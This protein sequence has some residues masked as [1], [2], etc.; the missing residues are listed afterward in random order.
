MYDS[1][2]VQIYVAN[3]YAFSN[4]YELVLWI[5][6][7]IRI[8]LPTNLHISLVHRLYVLQIHIDFVWYRF[9]TDSYNVFIVQLTVL[10]LTYVF[11]DTDVY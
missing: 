9:C 1:A 5:H 10:V 8:W 11:D 7:F 4:P 2:Y 6:L 3:L